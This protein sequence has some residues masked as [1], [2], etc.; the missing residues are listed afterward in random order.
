MA[1]K[2]DIPRATLQFKLKNPSS[3]T[4]FGPTPYLTYEEEDSIKEWIIKM[5]RKGFPRKRDDVLD[6]VQKFLSDNPR[7]TP[8]VNNR[9][10]RGW[11]KAFLKRHPSLSQR[12]SEGVT[13]ASACVSESDIKKWFQEIRNYLTNENLLDAIQDPQRVFNAD[14]SGFQTCPSTGRVLGPKGDKNIYSVEQGNPKESVTVLFTF[15]ADGKVC[16]PLIVFPYK[17]LPDRIA[18]S[19]PPKWGIDRSDTGWMTAEVF[20]Q[21]FAEIFAPYLSEHKIKRPVILFI[22]GHKSHITLQLSFTC[23]EL[24]IE[25]IALY[26]NTTR[27]TQPADVSVFGPLKKMYRKAVRRFQADNLGEV[28]T[29]MNIAGILNSVIDHIKPDTIIN[30]F[31]ACGLYPFDE[32]A[33]DYTKCLAVTNTQIETEVEEK[34]MSL[35]IFESLVGD[36]IVKKMK[37][38]QSGGIQVNNNSPAVYKVWCF[39]HGISPQKEST[40]IEIRSSHN[41][42]NVNM[43]NEN[44]V[45]TVK[46]TM[47]PTKNPDLSTPSTSKA[48]SYQNSLD[49]YL[50]E[51]PHTKRKFTK[52]TE[53]TPYVITS[54]NFRATVEKK[55]LEKQQKE[56]E[57]NERKRKRDEQAA[58]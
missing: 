48:T 53:K 22:D 58:E 15:S 28:V 42:T 2:Y 36:E 1:K 56:N 51:P 46:I 17:R 52:T 29:K 50:H 45:T 21:F 8:F 3:K 23:K 6:T 16:P 24:G 54:A 35:K 13:K 7:K 5:S 9:P 43:I 31:R 55:E 41:T 14:E 33:I 12:T 37:E 11:L 57:K 44:N 27:I 19:V 49:N 34:L 39:F 38:L 32:N 18:S 40:H 47:T 20:N 25:L 26:P 4:E 30:G 10:G